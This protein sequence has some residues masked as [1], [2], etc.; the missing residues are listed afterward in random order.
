MF[1]KIFSAASF[2]IVLVAISAR[3]GYRPRA[4]YLSF[5]LHANP[6]T[7]E[8]SNYRG[9]ISEEEAF[10]WFDEAH[11]YVRGGS[12]GAGAATFKFGKNRQHAAPSGGSGGNGGNI[13]FYVDKNFNTLFGFRG[14]A[15]FKAEHGQPGE[16]DY[17][18]GLDGSDFRVPVPLGTVVYCNETGNLIGELVA[19][20][21]ELIVAKGGIGG[22][23]NAAQTQRVRGEKAV[24]TPPTGG[25]KQW[26]RLELR[27][28]ADIGL[29]GMPNAGKS[30][31]LDAVTNA[32]PKIA[33]YAFTTIVPNLGVCEVAG[34]KGKG[35]DAMVIADIP[36]LVEG[37]HKGTGLGR[38]F[39]RH[40]ER[41]ELI[42]HIV[43]GDSADPVADFKAINKELLLFSPTLASKPQVVIVNKVDLPA[44]SDKL[45]CLMQALRE[46]MS[47][48]RLLS[49][50]AAAHVGLDEVIERTYNFLRK[51]KTESNAALNSQLRVHDVIVPSEHLIIP[52]EQDI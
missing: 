32:K 28:V 40:V 16:L 44:V 31:F 13:I 45:N 24:A 14:R 20:N 22:K 3:I 4:R 39:L 8:G 9:D 18:N 52:G 43:N 17:L 46:D 51:L 36:G 6:I 35:G 47:H 25:E 11:V 42:L 37:A 34:G 29:V 41:C 12:G 27:L 19:S 15:S 49:M 50:S 23:G 2:L 5:V 10:Q 48:K 38:G 1:T 33:D 21:Q 30:T 26:L 7:R